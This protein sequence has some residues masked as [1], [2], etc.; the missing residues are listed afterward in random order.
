MAVGIYY[1]SKDGTK[2]VSA[3]FTVR[4]FACK[5]K[6]DLVKIDSALVEKLEGLW[7]HFANQAYGKTCSIT[8][9]SAYRTETYNKTVGGATN[10]R[11]LYGEAADIVVSYP[12]VKGGKYVKVDP[13]VVYEAASAIGFTGIGLYNTFTHVDV[14][15]GSARW[16]Y[17]N[18]SVSTVTRESAS[19]LS[20]D[21]TIDNFNIHDSKYT[22]AASLL[23]PSLYERKYG[24]SVYDANQPLIKFSTAQGVGESNALSALRSYAQYIFFMLNSAMDV[25]NLAMPAAPWL[26]PGF[27]VWIDPVGIDKVYYINKI[28]HTGTASTNSVMT[29]LTLS[30]GRDRIKYQTGR[31]NFGAR[32]TVS[33]NTDNVFINKFYQNSATFGKVIP[34]S[35]EFDRIRSKIQKFYQN[36][37]GSV[38][39]AL[40]NDHFAEFYGTSNTDKSITVANAGGAVSSSGYIIN[41][42]IYKLNSSGESVKGIAWVLN[43]QG[44][45]TGNAATTGIYNSSVVAAVRTF[46][47]N[48]RLKVDGI[49]GP[50][51]IAKMR[52]LYPQLTATSTASSTPSSTSRPMH[53]EFE[54]IA[55]I[56]N[57]LNSMYAGAPSIVKNRGAKLASVISEADEYI[58]RHYES[59]TMYTTY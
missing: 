14:R 21:G 13:K 16:N 32:E 25:A 57:A 42:G 4:E 30:F 35:S 46:Q 23:S 24:I 39:H 20:D 45:N 8:I 52:S 36:D 9:N 34:S 50:A 44:L 12:R 6:S 31:V 10:S 33:E 37:S 43:Q 28:Q 11:H 5:D 49:T 58:R 55:D 22:K 15:P 18:Q 2:R 41:D 40:K 7:S 59:E 54:T 29:S 3:H 26:R 19:G 47:S 1:L 51:T 53:G 17:S 56:Q 27:N 48:Y 38:I